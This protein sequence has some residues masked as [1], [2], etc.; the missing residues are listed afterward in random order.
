MVTT[1][2]NLSQ[3]LKSEYDIEFLTHLDARFKMPMPLYPEVTLAWVS[4]ATIRDKIARAHAVHITTPEG[5]IGLKTLLFCN[6]H[7]IKYTTGYHTKW[8]E[9]I[10]ARLGISKS[11]VEKFMRWLHGNSAAVLVP[12]QSVAQE[13]TVLGFKNLVIWTRGVDRDVFKPR[14]DQVAKKVLLCVSRISHEKNLEAFCELKVQDYRLVLVG[15]GPYRK[16]L[17][18]KYPQVE[19]TGMLRGADLARAYAQADVLVFPSKTDTFGVVMIEGMATGT[20][21]AA[22]DVTGPRDVIEKGVTGYTDSDLHWAV[23]KSLKL[24]R[25]QVYEHSL[26]WSWHN[27]ARQFINTLQP[28]E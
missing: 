9:F 10:E 6:K 26:K 21:V 5:P 3:A 23:M 12:T 24:H 1:L 16:S 2:E 22:Y 19:F 7:G 28:K 15:D 20:P 17:E 11:I 13:L 8:P 18:H 27:C 4:T 14:L 25:D